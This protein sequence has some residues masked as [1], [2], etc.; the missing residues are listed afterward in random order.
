MNGF[1]RV[2]H[3]SPIAGM[4]F[5]KGDVITLDLGFD[6][7]QIM[8]RDSVSQG[9]S[10]KTPMMA[11]ATTA[12]KSKSE[13]TATAKPKNNHSPVIRAG[14]TKSVGV[15][16]KASPEAIKKWK[17]KVAALKAK[18]VTAQKAKPNQAAIDRWKAKVAAQKAL[19]K[20]NNKGIKKSA[21]QPKNPNQ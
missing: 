18:P 16:P 14:L 20:K 7:L 5:T 19:D 6:E 11:L 1:G 9:D 17:E 15:K 12:L 13:K 2:Y 4:S 10:I 8:K 21:V 3:Q